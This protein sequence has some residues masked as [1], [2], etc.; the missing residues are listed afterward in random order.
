MATAAMV[1]RVVLQVGKMRRTTLLQ[2]AIW[3]P[4]TKKWYLSQAR[5][6]GKSEHTY[7]RR[8]SSS[9]AYET[10]MLCKY[11]GH[12]M[13]FGL[14]L[15]AAGN[16]WAWIPW[17][18]SST[19]RVARVRFQPGKTVDA[20]N[21]W[22]EQF[23]PKTGTRGAFSVV[24]P[25]LVVRRGQSKTET[26]TRYREDEFRSKGEKAHALAKIT[27]S[28]RGRPGPFQGV[29]ARGDELWVLSGKTDKAIQLDC[30]SFKTGSGRGRSS[31]ARRVCARC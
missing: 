8:F 10:F 17:G 26:Y 13:P 7:I 20:R 31:S 27:I 21:R 15:S 29:T 2:G 14:R 19:K 12:G 25:H 28:K 16:V 11:A 9:G 23:G 6:A 18:K 24:W 4:K 3:E 1:C 5:T 30:F 22:V